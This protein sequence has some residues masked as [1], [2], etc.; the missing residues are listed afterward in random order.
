[1]AIAT[2]ERASSTVSSQCPLLSVFATWRASHFNGNQLND[3]SVSG[4][5]ADPD[6]DGLQNGFEFYFHFD[7]TGGMTQ[8]ERAELPQ[9]N[10][11]TVIGIEPATIG[12]L[13][14]RR[15]PLS[16]RAEYAFFTYRRL[17]G[18]GG[19]PVKVCVSDDLVTWDETE[20]HV[21]EWGAPVPT[22][23]GITETVKVFLAE[24]KDS[25]NDIITSRKFV[26]LKLLLT[27]PS[28]ASQWSAS[29]GGNDHWY[30]VVQTPQLTWTQARDYAVDR[31]GYLATINS[32]E[33]N[34]F[35]KS[36][37]R[38]GIAPLIG[39]YKQNDEW[40]WL[41]AEPFDFTSWN[42]GEPNNGGGQEDCVQFLSSNGTWNDARS[43]DPHS[44]VVEYP[45]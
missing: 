24:T 41:T 31:G 10:L 21:Q 8:T 45:Q 12:P 33:E 9:V 13:F 17:I 1:M 16:F 23:D 6:A 43:I 18:S 42:T 29:V 32:P 2:Q 34:S 40:H 28:S 20:A 3:F 44:C 19:I 22:G 4:W 5:G 26:R 30:D 11:E 7:P 27:H 39:G 35:L 36:I 37:V 25:T 14:L 15:K 38:P